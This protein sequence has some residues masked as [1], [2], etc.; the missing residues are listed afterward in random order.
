MT[1]E[2]APVVGQL[3]TSAGA[4]TQVA[5]VDAAPGMDGTASQTEAQQVGSL[6]VIIAPA[7]GFQWGGILQ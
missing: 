4:R 7:H 1:A 6:L 2:E 3:V 5:A